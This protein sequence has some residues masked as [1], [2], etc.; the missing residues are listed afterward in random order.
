MRVK[1]NMLLMKGI[2]VA[3]AMF[4]AMFAYLGAFMSVYPAAIEP[5]METAGDLIEENSFDMV[6]YGRLMVVYAVGM[7][8]VLSWLNCKL[9]KMWRLVLIGMGIGC[10]LVVGCL[11]YVTSYF[12]ALVPGMW[13]PI[14]DDLFLPA[15]PR[16]L[17]ILAML[18]AILWLVGGMIRRHLTERK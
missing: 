6:Q 4:L 11:M 17:L 18:L 5:Y 1:Y 3:C 8:I 9:E 12:E 7:V 13:N 10:A 14:V 2:A 16:F 15:V